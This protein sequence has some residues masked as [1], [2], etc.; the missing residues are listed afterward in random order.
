MKV[1]FG[2]L[3]QSVISIGMSGGFERGKVICSQEKC[4]QRGI[5]FLLHIGSPK[6]KRSSGQADFTGYGQDDCTRRT[7]NESLLR[8]TGCEM[9]QLDFSFSSSFELLES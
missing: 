3:L 1:K 8:H 2:L 9:H 5:D 4:Q 6:N 7:K